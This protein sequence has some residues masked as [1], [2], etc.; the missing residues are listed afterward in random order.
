MVIVRVFIILLKILF[1]DEFIGNLD[2]KNSEKVEGL[3]FKMNRE[4]GMMF[5]LVIYDNNLVVKCD[6]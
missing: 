4:K 3:L 1:V 5:V 6:C 2:V